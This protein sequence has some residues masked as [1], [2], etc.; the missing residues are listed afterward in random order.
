MTKL[1]QLTRHLKPGNVYRR[2]DLA[3]WSTSV[4]RHLKQLVERGTLKKLS[5]GLYAYPKKTVF[6]EAPAPDREVVSAF[7]KDDLFLLASP[8]AYN[9]LG[10]G[11]TQLYDKTV[12]YNHKR[13][14]DFQLGGRKFAFRVKPRFPKS[15]TKEFLLVDLVNNLDQLA[16]A[17][18][19]VLERV[20]ERAAATDAQRLRRA[21]RNYGNERTKKFFERALRAGELNHA[22]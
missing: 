13:H 1:E 15:L 10:V 16:E 17:K 4:D 21:V 12:V 19:E 6:G 2:A 9:S 22:A 7:L 5:G 11:T 20:R 8:N 3:R 18:S 14:G